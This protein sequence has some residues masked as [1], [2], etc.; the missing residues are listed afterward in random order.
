MIVLFESKEESDAEAAPRVLAPVTVERSK[1]EMH[2]RPSWLIRMLALIN[3][4]RGT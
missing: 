2:A 3:N 4:I 1:S